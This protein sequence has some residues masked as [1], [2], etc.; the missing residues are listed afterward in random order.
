M[1]V[2]DRTS[3]S[4]L[5]IATTRPGETGLLRGFPEARK[6]KGLRVLCSTGLHTFFFFC[7]VP[8]ERVFRELQWDFSVR[9]CYFVG[10]SK[11]LYKIVST[12]LQGFPFVL[13]GVWHLARDRERT[14]SL[15]F[16]VFEPL[17]FG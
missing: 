7:W 14:W 16:W 15:S 8:F 13:H 11:G 10:I 9:K 12:G 2:E 3:V 6:H 4:S 17:G 1:A 5:R